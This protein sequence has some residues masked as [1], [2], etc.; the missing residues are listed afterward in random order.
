V[1]VFLAAIAALVIWLGLNAGS[2]PIMGLK[3]HAL[4]TVSAGFGLLALLPLLRTAKTWGWSFTAALLLSL[5]LAVTAGLRPSFSEH[6][7]MRLNLRYVE[8]DGQARWMAD[9]VAHLPDSLRAAARFSDTPERFAGQGGYL[10]AAGAARFPAP[11]ASVHR[12]GNEVSVEL[13]A[14]GDGVALLVPK[15]AG[16]K[17]FRLGDSMVAAS[18][19]GVQISCGTPDCGSARIILSFETAAPASLT[20]IARRRGLPP[21]GAKLLKARPAWAVPSQGGD[22]IVLAR[23]I[24]IPPG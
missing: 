23:K 13:N 5:A 7:P 12:S 9:P 18:G 14:A 6:A 2:E 24:E 16:L 20:L 10:A 21:E 4:F 8:Q 1:A 3:T 17:S 11:S 22:V 15:E 19:R